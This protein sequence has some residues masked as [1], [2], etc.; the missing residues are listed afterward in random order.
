M[1]ILVTGAGGFLG[2][3]LVPALIAEGHAVACLT[4]RPEALPADWHALPRAPAES[5]G[6]PLR[7]LCAAFKPE[8]VVH[9]AGLYV[10][11]HR[12]EDIAPLLDANLRLGAHLLE[13][14]HES[15]CRKLVLAGTSWQ[16]FEGADYRPVNLY[17][18][19]KQAFSTLAE[20]YLDAAGFSLLEL[21]LYDSY[22]AGDPRKKLINLLKNAAESAETLGMTSGEQRLHLV[23]IDDVA[24][25]FGMACA[26]VAAQ[27]P[28]TR[29]VYR[30]PAAQTVSLRELV[31]QYNRVTPGRPA[32]IAWGARPYRAREV[33]HPWEDAPSLPGWSPTIDLAHGLQGLTGS[34]ISPDAIRGDQQ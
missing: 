17:A 29:R 10:S 4:R 6:Q 1:R 23:H 21:H 22:G 27:A 13:A 15:G 33:F 31:A 26:Q 25:G 16:H 3:H 24:R 20:Y 34:A 8:V 28:A 7:A 11:E 32:Q 5:T 30:L 2:R 14:M 18:A 19:T 9:L 12:F